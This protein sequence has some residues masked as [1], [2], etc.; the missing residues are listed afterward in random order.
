MVLIG[1]ADDDPDELVSGCASGYGTGGADVVLAAAADQRQTD[2][3]A[4]GDVAGLGG[5]GFG[6]AFGVELHVAGGVGLDTLEAGVD[7]LHGSIGKNDLAK[8]DSELSVAVEAAGSAH[9]KDGAA[10]PGAGGED[11]ASLIEQ[12]LGERGIDVAA[13]LG[14][15]RVER[16]R[17]H[18]VDEA[19]GWGLGADGGEACGEDGF[20]AEVERLGE[21]GGIDGS[22]IDVLRVRGE[23][24]DG[25]AHEDMHAVR[26]LD[27]LPGVVPLR[28]GLFH[29]PSG[30]VFHGV[31][32][33]V[34]AGSGKLDDLSG[35]GNHGCVQLGGAAAGENELVEI[36]AEFTGRGEVGVE[37]AEGAGA[38]GDG[39]N[40]DDVAGR[41]R[42]CGDDEIVEDVD[43]LHDAAVDG[44]AD[45][46]H[47]HL[48]VE[49]DLQGGAFGNGE[50]DGARLSGR[51]GRRG[52][53]HLHRNN[54]LMR[55]AM[56]RKGSGNLNRGVTA[57]RDRT[58]IALGNKGD[59]SEMRSVQSVGAHLVVA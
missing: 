32:L 22:G 19:S 15:L 42:A 36:D 52:W 46:A 26:R 1:G 23:L 33:L 16:R 51:L 7:G 24:G 21:F 10:E 54:Q 31:L 2:G 38:A 20:A 55:C 58:L 50:G 6:A 43:G 49:G 57:G 39:S 11:E 48:A 30:G 3:Y 13:F 12:R 40:G 34:F 35:A 45:L 28:P 41:L 27:L 18:G 5:S 59:F 29:L 56:E 4:R 9:L 47:A 44:L 53:I 14:M 37:G 25:V 8:G 17:Q